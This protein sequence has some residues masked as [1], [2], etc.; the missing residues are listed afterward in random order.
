M[1]VGDTLRTRTEVVALK[2]NRPREPGAP[3][4]GLVALRIQH[5]D[6][7]GEPVLDFWRCPMIP[8]RDAG[9]ARPATPTTFDDIPAD[10]RSRRRCAPRSPAGWRL[11]GAAR[12]G[13]RGRTAADLGAGQTSP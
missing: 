10:A 5:E 3:A 11:D 4:T 8:L 7:H 9:R 2:Q 12:G 13:A 6:Q 1:F